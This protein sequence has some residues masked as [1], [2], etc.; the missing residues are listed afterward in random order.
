MM[1]TFQTPYFYADDP[2]PHKSF[3]KKWIE[4]YAAKCHKDKLHHRQNVITIVFWIQIQYI[5]RGWLEAAIICL[6]TSPLSIKNVRSAVLL[7]P[8]LFL[9]FFSQVILNK[10]AAQIFN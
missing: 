1:G 4:M 2:A 10:T 5:I 7:T 6:H 9:H 8:F 3:E